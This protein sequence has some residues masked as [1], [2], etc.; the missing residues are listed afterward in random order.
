[1]NED[2]K[3]TKLLV[4]MVMR[5]TDYTY[6]DVKI[7]LQDHDNNYMNVIKEWYGIKKESNKEVKSINQGIYKEIRT[8]MDDASK[9]YRF[10]QKVQEK[11]KEILEKLQTQKINN[12]ARK[13]SVE[14]M[15]IIQE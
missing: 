6:D 12:E 11:R 7:K 14:K 4:E 10:K 15:D 9:Q 8:L 1:M 5:Q 13:N 2:D 3:Q